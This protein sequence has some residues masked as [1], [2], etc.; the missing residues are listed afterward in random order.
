[1]IVSVIPARGGSKGIRYKNIVPFLGNPLISYTITQS[2]ASESVDR[3]FVSTDDEKIADVSERHGA[4]VIERPDEFATDEATTESA[5]LHAV[6]AIR[7]RGLNPDI[8]VLLQCTS[9][10]RREHDVDGTVE[11]VTEEGRNSALSIC[12]D[13]KFYWREGDESAEPINYDPK[14]RKRRQELGERYQENGS[15][16]AVR[17]ETLEAEQCRL[18]GTIGL[19]QMPEYHSFE[20]D[21]EHD[22]R[23][24]ESIG[25]EF[26]FFSGDL[27]VDYE[28]ETTTE[29]SV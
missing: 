18:G 2:L 4:K 11:L 13:H 23:L 28:A 5:L 24:L 14:R 10:L 12:E 16:Y 15:I 6:E 21:D 19:Y 17:T 29:L 1:M 20:I 8:V 7:D 9:P 25:R 27:N 3:T 26:E 22:L